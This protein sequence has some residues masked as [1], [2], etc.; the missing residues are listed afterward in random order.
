M[1]TPAHE[2]FEVEVTEIE[3]GPLPGEVRAIV[4]ASRDGRPL[5]RARVAFAGATARTDKRGM[6]MVSTTLELPGRFKALAQKGQNYG[7]SVLAPVGAAP[8]ALSAP[9]PYSGAG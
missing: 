6:A 9:P 5:R 1:P 7:V 4:R 8:V 2:R 3:V